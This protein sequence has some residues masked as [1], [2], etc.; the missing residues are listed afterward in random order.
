MPPPPVTPS[1]HRFLPPGNPRTAQP[2]VSLHTQIH[3][4]AKRPQFAGIPPSQQPATARRFAFASS[5]PVHNGERA[6]MLDGEPSWIQA[7]RSTRNL[8]RVESIEDASQDTDDGDFEKIPCNNTLAHS[9]ELASSA[10]D[11][12]AEI[13]FTLSH[14]KRRRLSPPPAS[15]YTDKSFNSAS[16]PPTT[17]I[18]PSHRFLA[19]RAPASSS[20]TS[21]TNL[22]A[23]TSARPTFL[24]PSHNSANSPP[25][26]LP[27]TFSPQRRGHKFVPGGLANTAQSW[28]I[29]VAH[30][31]SHSSAGI[32]HGSRAARGDGWR[33]RIRVT[34][35]RPAVGS[36]HHPAGIQRVGTAE[37][38][39]AMILVCGTLDNS[40]HGAMNVQAILAGRGT[41][42]GGGIKLGKGSVVGMRAPYWDVELSG[43]KWIV[44]ADWSVL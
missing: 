29:D 12:E 16:Q 36:M 20:I 14:H 3:Q 33:I 42:R 21:S 1:P 17:P 43:E 26:P 2:A 35:T 9:I 25:R 22:G 10:E 39:G 23:E 27:D 11:E 4:P 44:A 37:P 13:L 32:S 5:R 38:G 24:L 40:Q 31:A 30:T 28:I 6:E 8:Q 19:P 15:A 7:P 41:K 18:P 34:D